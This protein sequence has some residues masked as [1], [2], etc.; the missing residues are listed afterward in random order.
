MKPVLLK[1]WKTRPWL[2]TTSSFFMVVVIAVAIIAGGANWQDQ[3][4]KDFLKQ[5]QAS[6]AQEAAYMFAFHHPEILKYIPC[7][8][9]CSRQ[10][11]KSNYNCFMQGDAE[12]AK[13]SPFDEHGLVCPMCV[14]IAL[15]AEELDH[16]G[17]SVREIRD[18]IDQLQAMYPDLKNMG[19]PTPM[20]PANQ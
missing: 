11:H 8:C 12:K 17:K 19:T 10:H 3:P 1:F 4:L 5:H 20:P 6:Q 13:I 15:K 16:Q 2:L 7:Y 9:G 18:Y 14:Q